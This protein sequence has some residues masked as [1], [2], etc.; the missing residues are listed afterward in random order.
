METQEDPP[1]WA[2]LAPDLAPREGGPCAVLGLTDLVLGLWDR[3]PLCLPRLV[4]C[5]QQ[6]LFWCRRQPLRCVGSCCCLNLPVPNKVFLG[7]EHLRD[8]HTFN[9]NGNYIMQKEKDQIHMIWCT[10]YSKNPARLTI[11]L[12]LCLKAVICCCLWTSLMQEF[13][14]PWSTRA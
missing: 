12:F 6:P 3:W 9:K 2:L 14:L 7:D 13:G 5:P 1:G 4:H 8:G 10:A 11:V